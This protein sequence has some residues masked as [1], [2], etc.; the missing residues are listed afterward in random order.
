MRRAQKLCLIGFFLALTFTVG[1]YSDHNHM[2]WLRA[3]TL[4]VA[5]GLVIYGSRTYFG[6]PK[7]ELPQDEIDAVNAMWEKHEEAKRD[8]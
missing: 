2:P 4:V 5:M 1:V 7:W 3:G 6:G 8:V